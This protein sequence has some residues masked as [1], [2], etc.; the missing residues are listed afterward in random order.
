MSTPSRA[1][2]VL[3]F[4]LTRIALAIVVVALPVVL[5]MDLA[6][7]PRPAAAWLGVRLAGIGLERQR[8]NVARD[9]PRTR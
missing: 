2:R 1:A 5:T 9:G 3:A 8:H 6:H 7:R 4:P